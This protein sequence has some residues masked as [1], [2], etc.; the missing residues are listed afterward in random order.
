[1]VVCVKV[2]GFRGSGGGFR[3][4]LLVTNKGEVFRSKRRLSL[5]VSERFS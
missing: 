4:L 5:L 1:M 3:A 2:V